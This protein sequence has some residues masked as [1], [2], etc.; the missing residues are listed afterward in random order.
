[1]ALEQDNGLYYRAG[2]KQL[3]FYGKVREQK[4]KGQYIPEIHKEQYLL[5]YE[6]KYTDRVSKHIKKD[7]TFGSLYEETMYM[8]LVDMW[9]Q[10]Y[11]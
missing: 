5:R 3:V 4:D 7:V 9:V 6:M 1:M 11:F 8:K 2:Q 10:E